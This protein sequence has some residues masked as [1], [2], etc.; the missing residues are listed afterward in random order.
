MISKVISGGQTGADVA[1]VRAAKA[2]GIETGGWMTLG[3]KTLAGPRPEYAEEFGMKEHSS[4]A[5][6][7]RT[8]ANARDS[9]GTMRFAVDWSSYGEICTQ[10]AIDYYDKPQFD[11][12]VANIES[13]SI[14]DAIRWI[15]NNQIKV[16]N[17][18]GNSE[19][20]HKGMEKF[21]EKYL[22]DVFKRLLL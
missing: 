1:G 9:D 13:T 19:S 8:Y 17:V 2:C 14:D 12:D 18:A 10:N 21:V 22:T 3:F 16:L 11:V 5:Y 20:T 4:P 7:S 15:I 6:P